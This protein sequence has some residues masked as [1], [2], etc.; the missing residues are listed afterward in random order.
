MSCNNLCGIKDH[1]RKLPYVCTQSRGKVLNKKPG[2]LVNINN[3][4]M[5][6]KNKEDELSSNN[7]FRR[8]NQEKHIKNE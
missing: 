2:I 5:R 1:P 7:E 4:V 8:Q 6:T 3:Q